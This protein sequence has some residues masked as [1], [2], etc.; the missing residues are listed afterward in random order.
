MD[1]SKSLVALSSFYEFTRLCERIGD[2]PSYTQ[3]VE[4]VKAH[5]KPLLASGSKMK[6]SE[7][8]QAATATVVQLT[9][10][11][12]LCKDDRKRVYNLRDRNMAKLMA[13]HWKCPVEDVLQDIAEGDVSETAKRFFISHGKPCSRST[14]TLQKVEGFLNKLANLTKEDD[15]YQKCP[16][17]M[18]AEIKYDGERIQIH[19]KGDEYAFFSRNLKK[20]L[21]WKVAAV[22]DYITESTEAESIILDGEILLMDTKTS[23]PLPFGSLAIHKKNDFQDATVCLFL[24]DILY[25]DGKVVMNEPL[26]K[27]RQILEES[28]TS[29]P[30]RIEFS[31][32][33]E[34]SDLTTGEEA[35]TEMMDRVLKEGLE[36][37]M[38]KDIGDV[39]KPDKRHWLKLKKDYLAGMA[40]SADLVVLG[41]YFGTGA[42][43][44]MMSVFLMG[45]YDPDEEKWKARSRNTVCKAGNGFD[46]AALKQ[47]Q[48]QLRPH[49]KQIHKSYDKW[50][51]HKMPRHRLHVPDFIVTDP[52][53]AP[54]WE[55]AGQG[56]TDSKHHTT[57]SIRFPRVTRIRDDKDFSTHTDV[58]H[59]RALAQ[60]SA[61]GTSM[62]KAKSA[63]KKASGIGTLDIK[64][65][66]KPVSKVGATTSS[67]SSSASAS[68]PKTTTTATITNWMGKP[69]LAPQTKPA[70]ATP[71]GLTVVK[72]GAGGG[73]DLRAALIKAGA[74]APKA[75]APADRRTMLVHCV[76]DAGALSADVED[77]LGLLWAQSARDAWTQHA[78]GGDDDE[79]EAPLGEIQMA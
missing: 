1:T 57:L 37:L 71:D 28:V 44:G 10:G 15:Q 27:R 46:D 79:Q 45:S 14:F 43:G 20:I 77:R 68:K 5:L 38:I 59:L 35:L 30:H 42:Y 24:F 47:L 78:A 2:E 3:K 12:L 75:A 74:S 33:K 65:G 40:D 8:E 34:I 56:F 73:A 19:K 66:G 4:V 51:P 60:A 22:R 70:A 41:A 69:K 18:F 52:E 25:V 50:N 26:K 13:R 55:V 62:T 21:E 53:Q 7:E 36:G 64:G 31:E 48:K 72:A 6:L 23:K 29:I 32:Y 63:A 76:N 16:R 58:V 17:G 11:L 67:S 9:C 39:Y 61:E 54:V 49:M